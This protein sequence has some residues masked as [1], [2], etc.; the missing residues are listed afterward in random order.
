MR[1]RRSAPP[2]VSQANFSIA[3]LD[4]PDLG[5]REPELQ[6]HHATADRKAGLSNRSRGSRAKNAQECL[7]R[8]SFAPLRAKS[9]VALPLSSPGHFSQRL[10]LE[11]LCPLADHACSA[12]YSQPCGARSSSTGFSQI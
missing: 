3:P 12:S 1:R 5:E 11:A 2:T 8:G 7:C 4:G 9:T 6:V 10:K